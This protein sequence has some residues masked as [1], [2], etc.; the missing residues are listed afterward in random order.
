MSLE[1][2]ASK[3]GLIRVEKTGP[4]KKRQEKNVWK[5]SADQE[6]HIS[7]MQM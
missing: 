2:K 4:G 3:N 1:D 6:K 7:R 5:V